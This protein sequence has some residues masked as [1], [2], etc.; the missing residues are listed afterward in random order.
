M[1][2]NYNST[3]GFYFFILLISFAMSLWLG[4]LIRIR[5]QSTNWNQKLLIFIGTFVEILI[6]SVGVLIG[7]LLV[8]ILNT[9]T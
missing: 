1:K 7:F 5:I 2:T 4:D 3:D 8:K 9:N 6:T